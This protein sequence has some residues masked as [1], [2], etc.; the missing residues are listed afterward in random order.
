MEET[1]IIHFDFY[2]GGSSY[3]YEKEL[4]ERIENC[5]NDGWEVDDVK[6]IPNQIHEDYYDIFLI[7]R[8]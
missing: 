3:D 5:E 6:I 7:F 8:R 2:T 1:K 4:R